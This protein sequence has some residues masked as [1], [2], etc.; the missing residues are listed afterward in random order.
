M[1]TE[2]PTHHTCPDCG[3][4]WAHGQHGGHSCATVMKKTIADLR[5]ELAAIRAQ[6]V[7]MPE[8]VPYQEPGSEY[9][10]GYNARWAS[11]LNAVARLNTAPVQQMGVPDAEAVMAKA[12]ELFGWA[13]GLGGFDEAVRDLVAFA[14][15]AAACMRAPQ[16]GDS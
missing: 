16:T 3:Y 15:P 4:T 12:R 11:G 13:Y 5:A 2:K 14:A 8:R 7:V 6:G 1:P 9:F 10:H